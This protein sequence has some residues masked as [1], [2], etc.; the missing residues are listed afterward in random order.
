[1]SITPLIAV[2]TTFSFVHPWLLLLLLAL[3]V[4]ALIHLRAE[5]PVSSEEAAGGALAR[6][7]EL[8]RRRPAGR[9]ASWRAS[10]LST[11]ALA[12]WLGTWLR[13]LCCWLAGWLAS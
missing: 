11:L 4:L 10:P 6:A 13:Q 9:L 3:P 7:R 5:G 12:D 2:G 1:M 8:H